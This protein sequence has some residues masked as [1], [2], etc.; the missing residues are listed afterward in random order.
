MLPQYY[1]KGGVLVIG[2]PGCADLFA[3]EPVR[4]KSESD[5][6]AAVHPD[7]RLAGGVSG[8]LWGGPELPL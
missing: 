1:F 5:F 2:F 8:G 7:P 6:V 4:E 3:V